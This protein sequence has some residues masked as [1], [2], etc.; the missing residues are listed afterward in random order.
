MRSLFL[1]LFLVS[2]NASAQNAE[3]LPFTKYF[4]TQDYEGGIQNW[5]ITQNNEG[6]IYVANNFGLL[7]YDAKSWNR[8]VVP[9]GTKMRDVTIGPGG[10]IYVAIQGNF[11]YIVPSNPEGERFISLAD[12]LPEKYRNFDE[13]WRIFHDGENLYFCTFR[14]IFTFNEEGQLTDIIEPTYAPEN[15]HFVN[16]RLFV[17]E[18][19]YGL[20]YLDNGKLK[21][22]EKGE[23]FKGKAVTSIIPIANNHLLIFTSSH[24]VYTWDGTKYKVWN[25]ENH[26]IFSSASVNTAIRLSSGNMA[27][28]TQNKGLYITDS[29]GKILFYLNKGNGLNN[30]TVLSLFE[31]IYGN[32]WVGHNNGI[33]VIELTVPFTLISEQSNLPGTGY[34]GMV[35]DDVIYLGTN[36]GLYSK[37]ITDPSI[38]NYSFV[39]NS[40]GQVYS[41]EEIDDFLLMGHHLGTFLINN[42]KVEQISEVLGAWTFVELPNHPDYI[43]CGTYKGLLLFKR[44]GESLK[45][46]LKLKGFDESSR[47]MEVDDSGYIWMTHGY[48]GVYRL[49]IHDELDSVQVKFYGIEKGLP[50]N[51]LINVWKINGRLIFST[52]T[53]IYSYN[54]K[55]DRFAPDEYFSKF[56]DEE[57]N[58]SIM[59]QDPLGNIYYLSSNEI[60]VLLRQSNGTFEKN[61]KIFNRL[62]GLLN[63]D[64]QN[65][66][67]L[68]SNQVLYGAKEG[69]ILY[70]KQGGDPSNASFNALIRK[71]YNTSTMK[72]SVV[73]AGYFYDGDNLQP[74]LPDKQIPEY[75]YSHNSI[76]FEYSAP[77][78]QG[79]KYTRFQY[80]LE[81]YD[82]DWSSWSE[83]NVKEYTN[84]REGSYT[85]KVR[86]IN[87][88]DQISEEDSFSFVIVAPWY[89][90]TFA[91][92]S[93]TFFLLFIIA[94]T[95][96]F[97]DRRHKKEKRLMELTQEREIS[98]KESQLRSSEEMLEKLKSEKLKAEVESKNQE[99]ATSTMHLLNKNSF[100]NSIK[101]NISSIIKRSKNQEVKKELNKIMVNIEKNIAS[102]D[103][104]E[105]FAIHFDQVHGDFTKRLKE[106]YPKLTPQEMKLSA[107]LRMNL[108]TKEIAHLLNISVRGVEIARY[109]LR[110]KL[111][112]ERSENLQEF[113]LKY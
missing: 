69:F 38:Q 19:E 24:G 86:A 46:V 95:F 99:L 111:T 75:H 29:N 18:L 37:N 55:T 94:S 65:L 12:S 85:F 22:F 105:H 23:F 20:T 67:I 1:I 10:K 104:W 56:F 16:N 42:R 44:E 4:S 102:D 88:Y 63:D 25:E 51:Y 17:N 64:L 72:D 70:T 31:D 62:K 97:I 80:K 13:A 68:N 87:I 57:S 34:D 45:F 76:K 30:R 41:I 14:Q 39:E 113:I 73:Y 108:S 81:N 77:F 58:I 79:S 98:Q 71:V 84:L 26:E 43:I 101:H 48:K 35:V 59:E 78:Y 50:S 96:Y 9:G 11:G 60:G 74:D 3:G 66:S 109:R 92:I 6:L 32:L 110:K 106:N 91:Y 83:T 93:G 8:Y 89:R 52:E 107:Y 33:S 112:L 21:L 27:I 15:F 53:T 2:L 82:E 28:G 5:S 90:T 47:V 40:S 103:D 100:I 61:T 54:E 36:N 49:H 7:E